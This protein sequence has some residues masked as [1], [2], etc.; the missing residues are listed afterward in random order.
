VRRLYRGQIEAQYFGAPNASVESS[1]KD[2][3]GQLT[4]DM[5]PP[6]DAKVDRQGFE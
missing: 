2:E 3:V 5:D 6:S 1:R 4:G